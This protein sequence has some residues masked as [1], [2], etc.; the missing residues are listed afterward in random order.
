MTTPSTQLTAARR[1]LEVTTVFFAATTAALSAGIVTAIFH[2]PA[3]GV[4]GAG[5]LTF[6]AAFGVG[7]RIFEH[8]RQSN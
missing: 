4:L 8:L 2:A 7:M 3:L 5:G 6:G 1:W